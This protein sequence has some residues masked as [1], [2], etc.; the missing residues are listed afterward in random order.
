MTRIGSSFNACEL[1]LKVGGDCFSDS[2]TALF[3]DNT[4]CVLVL[5]TDDFVAEEGAEDERAPGL[6]VS[7]MSDETLSE[8]PLSFL[9][10]NFFGILVFIGVGPLLLPF[11]PTTTGLFEGVAVIGFSDLS[12]SGSF[13][14]A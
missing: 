13:T 14:W 4:G 12:A 3:A 8:S 6:G 7:A 2:L 10:E 9:P 1:V 5:S 11:P